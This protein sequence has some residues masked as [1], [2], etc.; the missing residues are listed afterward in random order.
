M[1]EPKSTE[2][3]QLTVLNKI[4]KGIENVVEVLREIEK[5]LRRIK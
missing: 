3:R 2:E 1:P 4:A 5:E